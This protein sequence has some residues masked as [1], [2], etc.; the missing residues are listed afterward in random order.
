MKVLLTGCKGQLGLELIRQFSEFNGKYVY[1][2]TDVHNLDITNQEMV[3]ELVSREKPDVIIN[4]AAY[5]NVDGCETDELNAYKV[6]AVGPR[7]LSVAANAIGS[8]IV[9]IS[10]DYVFDGTGDEPKREYDSLNPQSVYGKS[11]AFAEAMVRETNPRHFIIRTAWLYG[12][13]NNFVRTMLKL[14][15]EKDELKVVSDQFGS[16]TSAKDLADCIIKLI[17]TE[18]Y[19]IYHGT[20]EGSCS[21]NE[22]AKKIFEIKGIDIKVSEITTEELNRPAKRPKYS[23]LDNFMLKMIGLNDFRNWEDSLKDY[24]KGEV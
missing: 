5:T 8:K 15:K 24:L 12:E 11:K 9:Q 3:S 17:N 16:P 6:N 7:N 4:C 10:T 21:W 19:G 20:C 1:I 13:G 22:F 23:V 18:S 2:E 14:S